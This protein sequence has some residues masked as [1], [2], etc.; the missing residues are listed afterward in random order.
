ML[1]SAS[2]CHSHDIIYR[3]SKDSDYKIISISPSDL[4][5][6]YSTSKDLGYTYK[7]TDMRI[8]KTTVSETESHSSSSYYVG[9]QGPAIIIEKYTQDFKNEYE[10]N[11]DITMAIKIVNSNKQN[12]LENLRIN[13]VIPKGFE[14]VR[15]TPVNQTNLKKPNTM[16][17]D[18]ESGITSSETLEFTLKTNESGKHNFGSTML[19]TTV[20]DKNG[21][22]N[23]VIIVSDRLINII[24]LNNPPKF[25][26]LIPEPPINIRRSLIGNKPL[27]V[28]YLNVTLM[29]TDNDPINCELVSSSG[30]K[31]IN[32]MNISN[33]EINNTT[34]YNYSFDI[35]TF[36]S[37]S[38]I[39]KLDA[40]D[41]DDHK[42]SQ[43]IKLNVYRIPPELSTTLIAILI[44]VIA[45]LIVKHYFVFSN[46]KRKLKYHWMLLFIIC[47]IRYNN[48]TKLIIINSKDLPITQFVITK[49]KR[50]K[51]KALN[52]IESNCKY[53]FLKNNTQNDVIRNGDCLD[54]IP[55]PQNPKEKKDENEPELSD[56]DLLSRHTGDS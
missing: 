49:H 15:A 14:F 35:S 20:V 41:G 2:L 28:K 23:D 6:E 51:E 39:L 1:M 40:S 46:I 27:G 7:T 4:D 13:E 18:L 50:I 42:L 5:I 47:Y 12:R 48:L 21:R 22:K 54:D 32:P 16:V 38:H 8:D 44:I 45:G 19:E 26:D 24:V 17:W 36:E 53:K 25:L 30:C 52:F 29:D 33:T 31:P 37:G 34:Y 43:D 10:K 3:T 56:N 11:E 55:T 9:S